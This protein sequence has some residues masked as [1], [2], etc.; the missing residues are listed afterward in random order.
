MC[1]F[2]IVLALLDQT[3][4]FLENLLLFIN[5]KFVNISFMK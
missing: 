3:G 4:L 2:N 1:S 5:V